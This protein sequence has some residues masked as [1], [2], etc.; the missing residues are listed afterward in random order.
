MSRKN[1]SGEG[2]TDEG[3]KIVAGALG[4]VLGAVL[5]WLIVG[6]SWAAIF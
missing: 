6:Y 5:F 4:I 2:S 1:N 3:A